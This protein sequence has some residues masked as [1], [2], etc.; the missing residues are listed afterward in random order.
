MEGY[1]VF[2]SQP[3]RFF[4]SLALSKDEALFYYPYG[5]TPSHILTKWHGIERAGDQSTKILMLGCGDIRSLLC[6]A[7]YH[8]SL[9][10]IGTN[11]QGVGL[12]FTLVDSEPAVL[13][14]NIILCVIFLNSHGSEFNEKVMLAWEIFYDHFLSEPALK[15]LNSTCQ[16]LLKLGD[17]VRLFNESSIGGRFRMVTERTYRL[18]RNIWTLYEKYSQSQDK[19]FL[20]SF[21]KNRNLLFNAFKNLYMKSQNSDVDAAASFCPIKSKVFSNAWTHLFEEYAKT[22]YLSSTREERQLVNP[23]FVFTENANDKYC[24]FHSSYP[25][26]CYNLVHAVLNFKDFKSKKEHQQSAQ[27]EKAIL[28]NA[29]EQFVQWGEAYNQLASSSPSQIVIRIFSGDAL[30]FCQALLVPHL[31]QAHFQTNTLEPIQILSNSD[32][33][34]PLS[35]DVIDT[36]SLVY[37]LGL[38]NVLVNCACLMNPAGNSILF[39]DLLLQDERLNVDS[40]DDILRKLLCGDT[41]TILTLLGLNLLGMDRS[42]SVQNEWPSPIG[43]NSN[44]VELRQTRLTWVRLN[45]MG[46]FADNCTVVYGIKLQIKEDYLLRILI[47]MLHLTLL[48]LMSS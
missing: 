44:E 41:R 16:D 30:E 22:G 28:E 18:L 21:N 29:R 43:D 24:I 39:T 36:S 23:T 4:N 14:R 10:P 37:N 33:P 19:T 34:Q 15:L 32:S 27:I 35:F 3:V 47:S 20:L 48:Y 46:G 11:T 5:N 45:K 40:L 25:L 26:K 2:Q 38:L 6:T 8:L 12:D 42:Y 31:E 17:D 1:Q 7:S 9:R 13:A